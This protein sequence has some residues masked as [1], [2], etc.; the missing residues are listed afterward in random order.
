MLVNMND[1]LPMA[2]IEKRAVALF[3]VVNLEMARGV[4]RAAEEVQAPVIIGAAERLLNYIPLENLAD[5]LLPMAK[6]ASIPVVVHFDHCITKE[7]CIKALE[8]GFTSVMYDCSTDSYEINVKKMK[9][10]AIIAHKY[11]AS[12]EGELGHVLGEEGAI[13]GVEA[14]I[15]IS[16]YYTEP[17]MAKDFVERTGIDALAIAVGTAHGTYNFKP[18]IDFNRIAQIKEKIE[19]PLVLHGGSGLSKSDFITAISNGISKINI[20]T[21]INI[22]AANALRSGLGQGICGITDV[23]EAETEAVY[24]E[25]LKILSLF[26]NGEQHS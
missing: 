25:S 7:E 3:N 12:I 20:F 17:N 2:R 4:I 26:W 19:T 8:L 10:M 6:R 11:G 13:T 9:E 18:K 24:K 16:K 22:A 5:L 15:D 14:Q 21:E 1:I 23:I